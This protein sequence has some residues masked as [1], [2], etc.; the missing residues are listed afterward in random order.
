MLGVAMATFWGANPW[1][2]RSPSPAAAD[3]PF[4]ERPAAAR[5]RRG[6]TPKTASSI[7]RNFAL[8]LNAELL[9]AERFERRYR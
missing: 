3:Q 7:A 1:L 4:A 5:R 2:I 6:S 9:R 8:A